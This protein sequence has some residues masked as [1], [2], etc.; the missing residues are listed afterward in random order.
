MCRCDRQN[1]LLYRFY[2]INNSEY[3]DLNY[4]Q[5]VLEQVQVYDVGMVSVGQVA[6]S[7]LYYQYRYLDKIGSDVQIVCVDQCKER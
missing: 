3:I 2:Q 6:M 7:D 4:I 1:D 5:E